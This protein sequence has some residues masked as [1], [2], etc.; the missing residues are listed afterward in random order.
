[1]NKSEEFYDKTDHHEE[2]FATRQIKLEEDSVDE[3]DWN[4][5][6]TADFEHSEL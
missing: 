3:L 2:V 6:H 1:M 4:S 5:V